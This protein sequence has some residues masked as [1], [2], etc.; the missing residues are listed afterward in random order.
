MRK[1]VLIRGPQGSGK[2]TL[3]HDSGLTPYAL[4]LDAVRAVAGAPAMTPDGR[5]TINGENDDAVVR[6]HRE[7]VEARMGRGE[8]LLI[9]QAVM[10]KDDIERWQ[11]LARQHHYEVVL[12]DLTSL[13][14]EVALERNAARP[15]LTR[16][17]ERAIRRTLERLKDSPRPTD[18]PVIEW[19]P[20]MA[21]DLDRW[22]AVPMLD[23]SAYTKVVHI[24]DLQ[25]CWT[26]LAG[27]GGPLSGG[28][29]PDVAYVFVGDLLDRG[30]ENAEVMRWFLDHACGRPN[31]FLIF[32][33]HEVHLRR[34]A[35]GEKAVSAEFT[36]RT[37]PQLLRAGITREDAGRVVTFARELL[38]YTYRGQPVLVTH[39]GLPTV[40]ERFERLSS[41]QYQKGT[42][43]WSDAVDERFE[44]LAPEGWVQ[45]H[46]HRNNGPWPIQA[47]PR[48]FNLEDS[49]EYGGAL[50]LA[51]LSP[52]GWSTMAYPNPVFVPYR[53][54]DL[55]AHRR[56]LEP[57]WMARPDE[58]RLPDDLLAAM[59][60]HPGVKEVV[61]ASHPHI[62]S[63]NFTRQV[64]Y[65]KAWDAV[66]MKA[67]GLFFNRDTGEIVARAYD[68]FFNLGERP[69]TEVD[70]VASTATFPIVG[71]RKDNG[72]LGLIGYD[73]QT[74][75]LFF[76]SK[77][78]PDSP[79]TTW[80]RDIYQ[81]VTTP[82]Q[83]ETLRRLLRDQEACVAVEVID[84]LNDPHLIDYPSPT[85]TLLDVF[86]RSAELERLPFENL[87]SFGEKVGL[88]AKSKEL[89][90]RDAD[91]LRGWHQRMASDLTYRHR[92][93]DLEGMVLED[94][95]GA[96]TKVKMAHYSFWKTM[97][98][99]KDRMGRLR[100][101]ADEQ[102]A[103]GRPGVNAQA[104]ESLM[105][106]Y[107][108][109]QAEAF[110]RWLATQP[111]AAHERPILDLRREFKA[112]PAY[113]PS[114]DQIPW[115]P[116]YAG[117]APED[118]PPKST[119]SPRSARP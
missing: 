81:Q 74:D 114:N 117:E 13:P 98:G 30:L 50:R 3:I 48:S 32:G 93:Q 73:R 58:T 27:P 101:S 95:A 76:S 37:L 18:I 59:R 25:G 38:A 1:L 35:D 53:E 54:R 2:S 75:A 6:L 20:R 45:V 17:P 57:D 92:D 90:L 115:T 111:T 40:P 5:V 39:A 36:Y 62:A 24:G 11:D 65:D 19:S 44:R 52:E 80:L 89:V 100:R 91:Q 94:A 85:L 78:T 106:R 88:S 42:G 7:L 105:A 99:A 56:A 10:L 116:S 118:T 77:S 12:V 87:A 23:L 61:S 22:L 79:F 112:S 16:V 55:Q 47:T 4:S 84:P 72:F 66:V 34:W 64:F 46:G 14:L 82:D 71:Y 83:R 49:V 8:L 43:N 21:E 26:V 86:H 97:R 110:L 103:K 102:A 96:M 68:K 29:D 108:H 15:E 60:A 51:T 119:R 67:R 107:A 63:L 41:Q 104:I 33:N 69:E 9:E 113:Q 70:A 31:V 109:P 28:L